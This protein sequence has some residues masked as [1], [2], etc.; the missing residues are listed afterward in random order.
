MLEALHREDRGERAVVE[1]QLAHVGDDR[2]ALL[3]AQRPGVDVDADRL[4]PAE[5]VVAVAD[6]AAEIEDE[7]GAQVRSAC[8]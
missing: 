2:L 7:P 8:A 5:Q 4:P 1:G 6:P 3:P